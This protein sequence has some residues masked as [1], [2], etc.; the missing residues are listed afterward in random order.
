LAGDTVVR[1]D[2]AQV[3][4]DVRSGVVLSLS[5]QMGDLGALLASLSMAVSTLLA[6]LLLLLLLPRG[7]DRVALASRSAPWAAAGWGLA[8]SILVPAASL[9][10]AATILGLPL[11]L[12]AILG[13]GLLWIVGLA[14]A[15]WIVGRL[16]VHEPRSRLG[17]F[18]AGWAI[19]AAVGLVPF[20]NVAWWTL[21]AVFGHGAAL[22]ATWRARGSSRHRLGATPDAPPVTEL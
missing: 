22:V 5:P 20:L 11:G 9:L 8:V 18:A 13:M 17:A 14:F 6:G 15:A 19:T 16:L 7:L 3:A 12:A 21:G 10:A 4:G 2:A 1:A